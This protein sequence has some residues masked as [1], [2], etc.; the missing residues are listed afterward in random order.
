L[1]SRKRK[2]KKTCKTQR[3]DRK[4]L[5]HWIMKQV[6][7]ISSFSPNL[8]L[9]SKSEKF[10]KMKKTTRSQF[11]QHFTFAFCANIF[12]TKK[13]YKAAFWMGLNFFGAKKACIKCWWNWHLE[14]FVT[15]VFELVF[16]ASN[17]F[18]P[19]LSNWSWF[20]PL[21]WPK[22]GKRCLSSNSFDS[23][24]DH[25]FF[26][27]LK[28]ARHEFHYFR[29]VLIWP[30]ILNESNYKHVSYFFYIFATLS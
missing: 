19:I 4:F 29:N 8:G 16:S 9:F 23:C 7:L 28:T 27:N 14:D 15:D 10:E 25:F 18:R 20:A 24:S 11:H 12:C 22:Q 5:S 26:F 21:K 1:V 3:T 6:L 13:D 17:T 30:F 2:V